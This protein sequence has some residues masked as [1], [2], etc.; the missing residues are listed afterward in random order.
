MTPIMY[1]FIL[2]GTKSFYPNTE[3]T[4]TEFQVINK[5]SHIV[6]N[7]ELLTPNSLC[8]LCVCYS[9]II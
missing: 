8:T 3:F 4:M 2:I 9:Y 1:L 6:V 7:R 5:G